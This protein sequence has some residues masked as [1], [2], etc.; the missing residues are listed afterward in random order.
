M[1]GELDA[2]WTLESLAEV[3]GMSRTAFVDAFRAAL[4]ETPMKYLA[5]YRLHV[6]GSWLRETSS[7]VLDVALRAGYRTE[8]AFVRAFK[9][10]LGTTPGATR[11]KRGNSGGPVGK[12]Q[13]H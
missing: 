5:R 10:E 2:P 8:A 4:G 6:A 7:T 9:R 13:K 3:A 11:V 12:S 1:H